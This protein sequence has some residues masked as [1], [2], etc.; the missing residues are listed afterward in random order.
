MKSVYVL[1]YIDVIDS[2]NSVGSGV[3]GVF[4]TKKLAQKE[5]RENYKADKGD[6]CIDSCE[7]GNNG[8]RIDFG[9]YDYIE[10]TITKLDIQGA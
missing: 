8:A 7:I 6:G 5:M 9:D 1:S 3:L 4:A 10:Y 2:D